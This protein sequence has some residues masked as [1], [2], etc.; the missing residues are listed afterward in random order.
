ML[1][2]PNRIPGSAPEVVVPGRVL[3]ELQDVRRD[4]GLREV[5]DRIPTRFE[6]QQNVLAIGD[7]LATEANAHS[8]TRRLNV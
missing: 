7:P 5:G 6:E 4:V 8:A 3:G 2:C 1:A